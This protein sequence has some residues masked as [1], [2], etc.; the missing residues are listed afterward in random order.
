MINPILSPY[1]MH[2][3]TFLV[4]DSH[5]YTRCVNKHEFI[6]SIVEGMR[7]DEV[8]FYDIIGKLT[9]LPIINSIYAYD[10]PNTFRT[11]LL[12]IN[13]EIYSKEMKHKN[14]AC[15]YVTIIYD[16]PPHLDHTGTGTFI[17]TFRDYDFP[18]KEYGPTAYI[19]LR[20]P[21][22]DEL[23]HCHII[24]ITNEDKWET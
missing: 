17:I 15:E 8:P 21:S 23:E 1:D 14:Q 11:I 16:T 13:H 19:C 12:Q 9:D 2:I 4:M 18:L 5:A 24:D 3:Y 10:N 6:E 20:R 22:E 7:V